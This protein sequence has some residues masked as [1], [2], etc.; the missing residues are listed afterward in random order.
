MSSATVGNAA[1]VLSSRTSNWSLV[2]SQGLTRPAGG[3]YVYARARMDRTAQSGSD[4]DGSDLGG[5]STEF[6][7][8][9]FG[10]AL[11]VRVTRSDG[12]GINTDNTY[13][14]D[15]E[16]AWLGRLR[17]AT[18][19]KFRPGHSTDNLCAIPDCE[20]R[21]SDFTYEAGTLLLETEVANAH[22]TRHAIRT[23]YERDAFGNVEQKT[24][25]PLQDP[26]RERVENFV[27]ADNLGRRLA[28]TTNSDGARTSNQHGD[29]LSVA[30][31]VPTATRDPNGLST[32]SRI[33][34]FGRVIGSTD[35]TGLARKRACSFPRTSLPNISPASIMPTPSG[36]SVARQAS[37]RS[38]GGPRS[39][40]PRLR[41]RRFQRPAKGSRLRSSSTIAP[42]GQSGRSSRSSTEPACGWPSWTW[43][44]TTSG[45]FAGVRFLISQ[46]S[47]H[48][49]RCSNMTGSAASWRLRNRTA[50]AP[51]PS[52]PAEPPL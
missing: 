19:R 25:T 5:D 40:T 12:S 27:Y 42:A 38:G 45:V 13:S 49:G 36:R 26:S 41:S 11:T 24:T 46:A 6:T 37:C 9:D 3:T 22:S 34:G 43:N 44:M 33:D 30:L 51:C 39:A 16:A 7:Y 4:L 47:P 48:V 21:R 20:V 1:R 29:R 8:D 50:A 23:S 35:P 14:E 2:R 15:P 52:M 32:S 18:V 17:T 31:A 28:S 10:N